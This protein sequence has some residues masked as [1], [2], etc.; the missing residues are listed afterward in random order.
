MPGWEGSAC[1]QYSCDDLNDCNGNGDCTNDS[2]C[3]CYAGF[4]GPA[5]TLKT[6]CPSVSNCS[7]N[8]ICL[9]ETKC[10]CYSGYYG[11]TCEKFECTKGCSGRG[12]CEAPETCSCILGWT[13]FDCSTP[14]CE[15][16]HYCSGF[17][18]LEKA[19]LIYRYS[20]CLY[21]GHG[22]CAGVNYC[23]CDDNWT[24]TL[25][26]IF[27]C[28]SNNRSG[29]CSHHGNCSTPGQ[30]SCDKDYCGNDCEYKSKSRH[31]CI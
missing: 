2:V 30:C 23:E 7:G 19:F 18:I 29:N 22:R 16:L 11:D 8:G 10:Q 24:G 13:G 15:Q 1:D 9:N 6:V 25:C 28:N 5:C 4:T 17:I 20:I 14:S 27:T 12:T 31:V 26:N 3:S 21:V